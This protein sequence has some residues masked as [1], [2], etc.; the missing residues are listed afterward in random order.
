MDAIPP[1][2][3][4][5]VIALIVIGLGGIQGFFRGFSGELARLFGAVIAF[6]A[7]TLLHEPVGQWVSGA[8][9]LEARPAQALA[10][11]VTV[12]IAVV[13]MVVAHILLKKVIKLVFAEGFDKTAG[14]F[15][16]LLRM[17]IFVCIFFIIMNMIPVEA[18]NRRFGDNS[19]VG[20]FIVKY[21]PT[22][23]KTLERAGITHFKSSGEQDTK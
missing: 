21:V 5:D 17:S 10:F 4:V 15:A 23:E 12:I 2:A 13:I 8:T 20:G 9:S 3:L 16:G 1:L 7:G 19:A 6:I 18:L 11:I 14:V 22:V